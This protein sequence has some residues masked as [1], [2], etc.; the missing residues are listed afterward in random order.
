MLFRDTDGRGQPK[1]SGKV[2]L[3]AWKTDLKLDYPQ[4]VLKL[5]AKL[6]PT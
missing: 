6:S 3:F 4:P 1:A 2:L 5:N